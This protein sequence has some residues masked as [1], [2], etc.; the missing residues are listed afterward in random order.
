MLKLCTSIHTEVDCY[1]CVFLNILSKIDKIEEMGDLF[2][3]IKSQGGHNLFLLKMRVNK[4]I[5]RK[6]SIPLSP[7]VAKVFDKNSA[8]L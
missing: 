2:A 8:K 5:K 6:A 4:G 3:I 1:P 7:T